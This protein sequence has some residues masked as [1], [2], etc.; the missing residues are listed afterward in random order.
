MLGKSEL[1]WKMN[2]YV[3]TKIVAEK[4][5]SKSIV[6]N[7]VYCKRSSPNFTSIKKCIEAK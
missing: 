3:A 6:I 7:L 4:F 5:G 2:G 1:L